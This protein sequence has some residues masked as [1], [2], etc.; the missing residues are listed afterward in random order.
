M[1]YIFN[2]SVA[3]LLLPQRFNLLRPCAPYNDNGFAFNSLMWGEAVK[4]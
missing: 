3:F 2:H 1:Q 4:Y